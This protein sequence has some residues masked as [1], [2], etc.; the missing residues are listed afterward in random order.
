MKRIIVFIVG[1][2]L[3]ANGYASFQFG[4]ETY[5]NAGQTLIVNSLGDQP[6]LSLFNTVGANG[7]AAQSLGANDFIG[8]NGVKNSLALSGYT[9]AYDANPSAVASF[10]VYN[11]PLPTGPALTQLTFSGLDG[12]P[13]TNQSVYV[14]TSEYNRLSDL[15]QAN[16]IDSLNAGLNS[17]TLALA[18]TNTQV[19]MNT[20]NIG[21]LYTGLGNEANARIAGDTNLQSQ[22]NN[23][24]G[25]VAQLGDRVS[26]LE[27]LK[28]M[29]EAAVRFYDAKHLSLVAYDDYDA[30]N[31]RNYAVG[32]RVQ[33]KLG[34]SYEEK[35]LDKQEKEIREL[36]LLV[37]RLEDK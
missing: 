17:T 1:L 5:Q 22:I 30:T 10:G 20:A 9:I 11:Q 37:S 14:L 25:Q 23:T 34:K 29:P 12:D 8:E 28:V 15:G 19:N 35:R 31:G 18:Q 16:S 21:A 24:N 4:S 27:K 26:N 13:R 2:V 32:V 7:V 33:L 3:S 36:K 6:T